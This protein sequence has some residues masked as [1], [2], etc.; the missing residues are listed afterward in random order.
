VVK[1][2]GKKQHLQT[3]E[4]GKI[5]SGSPIKSNLNPSSAVWILLC[6]FAPKLT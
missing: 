5:K 2:A 6:F 3:E 1:A 4:T